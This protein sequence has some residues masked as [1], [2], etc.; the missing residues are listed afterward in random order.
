MKGGNSVLSAFEV[1]TFLSQR[2]KLSSYSGIFDKNF[3]IPQ[4][5]N[6]IY[7]EKDLIHDMIAS[8]ATYVLMTV[9]PESEAVYTRNSNFNRIRLGIVIDFDMTFLFNRLHLLPAWNRNPVLCRRNLAMS[10]QWSYFRRR[11]EWSQWSF[12]A[13]SDHN[14]TINT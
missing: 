10:S 6:S 3:I 8:T 5:L 9:V 13:V 1:I 2:R 12:L 4:R 7:L 14:V 11:G